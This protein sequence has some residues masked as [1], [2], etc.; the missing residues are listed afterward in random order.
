MKTSPDGTRV[1]DVK[2]R[3]IRYAAHFD[4]LLYSWYAFQLNTIYERYLAEKGLEQ[5]VV[6]FRRNSSRSTAD[7]AAHVVSEIKERD[8]CVVMCFDISG[9]YDELNHDKLKAFWCRLLRYASLDEDGK[10]PSDHY[11][12]FRSLVNFCFVSSK[13]VLK[14]LG[15]PRRDL[16]ALQRLCSPQQLKFLRNRHKEIFETQRVGIPQ[17]LPI[18]PVLSNIYMMDFDAKLVALATE[19][20]GRYLRYCDDI[21]VICRLDDVDLFIAEVE[22]GILDLDL[23]INKSKTEI[24]VFQPALEGLECVDY[25]SGK[26]SELSYLGITYNGKMAK[27]RSKSVVRLQRRLRK[28][29]RNEVRDSL[30]DN[31]GTRRGYIISRFAETGRQPNFLSYAGIVKKALPENEIDAQLAPHINKKKIGKLIARSRRKKIDKQK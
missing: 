23:R 28:A 10:L 20:D 30:G 1:K 27:L 8:Q 16:P 18:S 4:A 2:V 5:A 21:L 15:I 22:T 17:G 29:V 6:A 7:V 14:A 13:N 24:K 12:I 31:R 3:N 9:F 11:R 25:F 26:E 19:R